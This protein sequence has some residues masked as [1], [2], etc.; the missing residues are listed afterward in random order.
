MTIT[1]FPESIE[2][3]QK[4]KQIY[5]K[6]LFYLIDKLNK[7]NDLIK[8]INDYKLSKEYVDRHDFDYNYSFN[9]K[10]HI[11]HLNNVPIFFTKEPTY[12]EILSNLQISC[13]LFLKKIIFDVSPYALIDLKSYPKKLDSIDFSDIPTSDAQYLYTASVF[14]VGK[15]LFNTNY[16]TTFETIYENNRNERNLYLHRDNNNF[17]SGLNLLKMF[18]II[19]DI[20]MKINLKKLIYKKFLKEIPIDDY[21]KRHNNKIRCSFLAIS[22]YDVDIIHKVF[23]EQSRFK[24]LTSMSYIYEALEESERCIFFNY[25]NKNSINIEE[26]YFCPNCTIYSNIYLNSSNQVDDKNI[27]QKYKDNKYLKSLIPVNKKENKFKCF[28]CNDVYTIKPKYKLVT[29]NLNIIKMYVIHNIK[30]SCIKCMDTDEIK[31]I[32]WK[33]KPPVIYCPVIYDVCLKCGNEAVSW[34]YKT[35][36]KM[37]FNDTKLFKI[38][39]R[40]RKIRIKIKKKDLINKSFLN[41]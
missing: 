21:K 26:H 34:K 32:N 10:R 30:N 9:Y 19:N 17:K 39:K 33:L 1:S 15:S 31:Y 38:R 16:N 25:E 41:S 5:I 40:Y 3:Y 27:Y 22:R 12:Y 29:F 4:A 24:F 13:E 28:C 11:K 35:R 18:V 14:L 6:N 7:E 36:N 20:F 37:I 8:E 2:F 23:Y